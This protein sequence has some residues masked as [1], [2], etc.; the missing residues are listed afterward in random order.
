MMKIVVALVALMLPLSARAAEPYFY[1]A[2][3]EA[4]FS[5]PGFGEDA[6]DVRYQELEVLERGDLVVT[7][8]GGDLDEFGEFRTLVADRDPPVEEQG[9]VI[10]IHLVRRKLPFA[11]FD[12]RREVV[13][14]EAFQPA[15]TVFGRIGQHGDECVAVGDTPDRMGGEEPGQFGC[16]DHSA[17]SRGG[18]SGVTGRRPVGFGLS[19]RPTRR[20][21]GRLR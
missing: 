1:E 9:G 20:P 4:V 16:C 7:T 17:S 2:E 13:M 5:Q 6:I 14:G 8:N 18:T 15:V 10:G 3:L 11:V 19:P 12:G 21:T